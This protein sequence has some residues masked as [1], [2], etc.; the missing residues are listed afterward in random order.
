[1]QLP[2]LGSLWSQRPAFESLEFFRTQAPRQSVRLFLEASFTRDRSRA[3]A[4]KY[5][6]VVGGAIFLRSDCADRYLY[7]RLDCCSLAGGQ[8]RERY[9]EYEEVKEF[10]GFVAELTRTATAIFSA[11][12]KLSEEMP[13]GA[14][15]N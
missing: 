6:W 5:C 15:K 2:S 8:P 12:A 11:E 3:N 13:E 1:L 4:G 14:R 7:S 9:Y 10:F